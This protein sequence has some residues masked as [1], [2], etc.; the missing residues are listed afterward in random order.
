ML[1]RRRFAALAAASPLALAAGPAFAR[2]ELTLGVGQFEPMVVAVMPFDGS[3]EAQSVAEIVENNLRRCGLF[4]PLERER[5]PEIVG[6]DAQPTFAAWSQLGVQ[7]II[8]GRVQA[9]GGSADAL[10]RLWDIGEAGQADGQQLSTGADAFRRL[11]HIIADQVYARITG[12]KGFFDTR[13]AFID[14]SGPKDRRRKRLAVMDSDG[15]NV[16]PLTNGRDLVVTP[17]FSP[18]SQ[19]LTYMSFVD[20]RDPRVFVLDLSGGRREAVGNFPGMT[21][22]PRFSPDGRAIVMSLQTGGDAN[23]FRMDLASKQTTRLTTGPSIDTSPSYAPDGSRIVFESDRGGRQQIYVMD[24]NGGG[25]ER[26]SF[27]EGAYSTPVWSP[28]GDLIAFTKQAG[29]EFAIGVM[30]PDGSGER[31][32]TKS[33]H[34]EGP[35]WAPNGRFLA[36]FSDQAGGPKIFMTDIA[37]RIRAPIPTPAFGSDPS[38]GPLL[39]ETG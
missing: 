14:E 9:G 8:S 11:G 26:I 36:F 5:F 31:I 23:L 18:N 13:I 6:I 25:A 38:W 39:T 33:F 15:A 19:E 16:K 2:L 1:S 29:G 17:R 27:G 4:A 28:K 10:Y 12:E 30:R 20:D 21:F 22:A 35:S 32:L 3:A 24:A 37:G 34:N 7:A